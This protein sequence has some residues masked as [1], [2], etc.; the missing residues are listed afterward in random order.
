MAD[1]LL[2]VENTFILGS[3]LL[4]LNKISWEVINWPKE[5]CS[6]GTDLKAALQSRSVSFPHSYSELGG[7]NR[8]RM[9]KAGGQ[10]TLRSEREE[11]PTCW[12]WA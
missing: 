11:T 9:C 2:E 5:P 8:V 12:N 7:L 6:A 4:L 1:R 3:S 10:E